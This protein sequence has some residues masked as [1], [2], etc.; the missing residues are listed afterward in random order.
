MTLPLT[1]GETA[2]RLLSRQLERGEINFS[3]QDFREVDA[4]GDVGAI[5][6]NGGVL[7]S[8]TTPILRAG[9]AEADEISWATTEVDPIQRSITL[10]SD[11]DGTKD[12]TLEL[13][14]N[15]GTTDAA[16]FSVETS[17]DGGTK[18]VDSASDAATKSATTH[19][20]SATIAA[21][22]IPDSPSRLTLHLVPPA[23][24]TNAIQ[25]LGARLLYRRKLTVS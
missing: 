20:I 2:A 17:W 13:Y 8:D 9:A 10:P 19:K 25:L 6:A 22:D 3:L 24:A 12:A 7:A 4:N 5:A 23:H 21:A 14:V 11:F 1:W 16:T 15:S 18:V